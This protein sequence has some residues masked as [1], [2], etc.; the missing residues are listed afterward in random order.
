MPLVDYV[1]GLCVGQ[2]FRNGNVSPGSGILPFATKC[3]AV[4]PAGKRIYFR[5]DSAAYQADVINHYSQPRRTFTITA[6]L[7]AAVKREIQN[8]PESGWRPYRTAE[9][10]ATDRE[11][12]ETVHTMKRDE[13][14]VPADRAALALSTARLV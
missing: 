6:D 5:S 9:G 11:I 10:P 13:A 3:E 12:A 2:E 4:L 8:L 14:G 1:H 7:D